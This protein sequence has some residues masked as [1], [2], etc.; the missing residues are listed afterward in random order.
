MKSH[1]RGAP[2]VFILGLLY[3]PVLTQDVSSAP[4]LPSVDGHPFLYFDHS[5][6]VSMRV[7]AHSTHFEL[8]NLLQNAAESMLASPKTYL[9]PWEPEKFSGRWNELYGNNLPPL[10]LYC[11]LEPQRAD[12]LHLALDYMERMAAQPTWLVLNAPK[13]E[14]PLAHSLI[15]F[16]TAFDFLERN[17]EPEQRRRFTSALA[18][19]THYMYEM[20]FIR[21]WGFQYLHNHQPTNCVALLSAALVLL[22]E[23]YLQE[24]YLWIQQAVSI[25]ERAILLLWEIQDGSLD[26]GIAYGT[27]T[28][29]SLFQYIFLM[30]RH[31]A[32]DHTR[33]PWLLKHFDFL[34]HTILPGFQQTVA[35]ADSNYNWFYGPESQLAFLES[36]VLHNGSGNWLATQIRRFRPTTGLMAPS[37]AQRWC[38]LHTEFI[39]YNSSYEPRPPAEYGSPKLHLFAD[40]GVATYGAAL[41][42]GHIGSFLAFKSGKLGG[43]AI[44]DIVH[45]ERYGEWI[46]GWRNFNAGHEHPDQNSFVFA[47]HGTPFITE[48]LYGPKLSHL[49]N[50]LVFGADIPLSSCQPSWHGQLTENCHSKWLKYKEEPAASARGQ[51]EAAV[52][53]SG[54]VF[55][56]GEAVHAYSTALLLRSVQRNLLLIHPGLLLALDHLHLAPGSPVRSA[57]AFFHNVNQ[58]FHSLKPSPDG[59]SLS[60]A[61]LGNEELSCRVYWV[62]DLGQSSSANIEFEDN[63]QNFP[64]HS[65]CFVNVTRAVSKELSRAAFAFLAPGLELAEMSV[66]GFRDAVHISLVVNATAY[67]IY[68]N[69]GDGVERDGIFAVLATEGRK[70][71]MRKQDN[72]PDVTRPDTQTQSSK[73]DY[74]ITVEKNLQKISEAFEALEKNAPENWFLDSTS[75]SEVPLTPVPR[76]QTGKGQSQSRMEVDWLQRSLRRDGTWR[77]SPEGSKD[78]PETTFTLDIFDRLERKR[79]ADGKTDDD[80]NFINRIKLKSMSRK[81]KASRRVAKQNLQ[82]NQTGPNLFPKVQV[83]LLMVLNVFFFSF[84]LLLQFCRFPTG[85]VLL[86]KRCLYIVLLADCLLLLALYGL[87]S[88]DSC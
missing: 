83:H 44:Y 35:I 13:D 16:A 73:D 71:V 5:D 86:N 31:F 88:E 33:H 19:A 28:T 3:Y 14:V 24:A 17:F 15:G 76:T 82:R 79:E 12:L 23:G 77:K 22:A 56:R 21:G 67:T 60:G 25:M 64:F 4:G 58:K 66:I 18:N 78:E 36:F 85:Q 59:P 48:A 49:N 11:L 80:Q 6:I 68:I 87:C 57:A 9:P 53:S 7:L 38:T 10:A 81:N 70:W 46:H 69:T 62:D 40:W 74:V 39:W 32:L 51:L 45:S 37:H 41:P 1:M 26:E 84:F 29:R 20:S 63:P 75:M 47:P 43:Q 42:A 54:V 50:V 55:M 27:Y 30:R 61:T 72:D 8:A 2:P 52:E 65:T 34:Y